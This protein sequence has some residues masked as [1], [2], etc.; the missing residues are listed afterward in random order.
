M[1]LITI[2]LL[3]IGLSMDALAVAVAAGHRLARSVASKL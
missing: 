1:D 3:A 2:F